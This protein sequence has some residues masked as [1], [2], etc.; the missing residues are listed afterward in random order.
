MGTLTLADHHRVVVKV[1]REVGGQV[2]CFHHHQGCF[3]HH[4]GCF[5]HHD[6]E[7]DQIVVARV[8][9][10]VVESILANEENLFRDERQGEEGTLLLHRKNVEEDCTS[11]ETNDCKNKLD[12]AEAEEGLV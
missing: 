1:V 2:E 6:P 10:E 4:Q 8:G 5:H 3:H 12:D 11:K 9:Q 7:E